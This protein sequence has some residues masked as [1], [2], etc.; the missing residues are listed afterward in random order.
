MLN[1]KNLFFKIL[2]KKP[3]NRSETPP[4]NLPKA[5]PKLPKII[6][7]LK[8]FEDML[9]LKKLIL[10]K[11]LLNFDLKIGFSTPNCPYFQLEASKNKNLKK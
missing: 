9:T 8:K 10:L 1:I 7:I 3:L 2:D 11:D 6:E 5:P 4:K